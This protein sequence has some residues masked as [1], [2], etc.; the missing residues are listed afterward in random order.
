VRELRNCLERAAALS[1]SDMLEP[2]QFPFV[3][4]KK[5]QQAAGP[6]Q[7]TVP[8]TVITMSLE[9]I[10]REHILRVLADREGNRERAAAVLGIST[11]TLYRKLREYEACEA[12]RA[13][14]Q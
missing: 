6:D 4:A 9:D 10:E 8:A 2:A 3:S 7:P 1:Q 5:D 11:R 13:A 14:I 12:R